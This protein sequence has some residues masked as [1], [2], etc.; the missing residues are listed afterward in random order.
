MATKAQLAA[1]ARRRRREDEKA[2]AEL[3]TTLKQPKT[4][5]TSGDFQRAPAEKF[6][7]MFN[8]MVWEGRAN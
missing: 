5:F 2:L 6:V 3:R 8:R 4:A 1:Y 7:R